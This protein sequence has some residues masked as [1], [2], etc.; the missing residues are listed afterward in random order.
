MPSVF[1]SVLRDRRI[2]AEILDEEDRGL[3]DEHVRIGRM[4]LVAPLDELT[5]GRRVRFLR[6]QIARL[7]E[8]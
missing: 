5:R 6:W 8:R 2:V 4:Q 3:R 1:I 7:R